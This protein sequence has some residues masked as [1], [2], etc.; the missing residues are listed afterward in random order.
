MEFPGEHQTGYVWLC[1][2]SEILDGKSLDMAGLGLEQ[3]LAARFGL[4]TGAE[5]TSI[6]YR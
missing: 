1:R 5:M 6:A 3:P 4:A 2:R